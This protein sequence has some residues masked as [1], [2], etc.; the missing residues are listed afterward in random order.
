MM[1]M[2]CVC[3]LWV[4]LTRHLGLDLL[5]GLEGV[6]TEL[7]S[8]AS[9]SLLSPVR[10]W[11]RCTANSCHSIVLVRGCFCWRALSHVYSCTGSKRGQQHNGAGQA[12]CSTTVWETPSHTEESK[13][14]HRKGKNCARI[15]EIAIFFQFYFATFQLCRKHF[16]STT[17]ALVR[18]S[19]G[20]IRHLEE[21]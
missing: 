17:T 14:R 15:K 7:H 1:V 12:G 18:R 19:S 13:Q 8:S 20:T 6:V 4:F 11:G 3:S 2:A 5:Q 9:S 21:N 16:L 10:G